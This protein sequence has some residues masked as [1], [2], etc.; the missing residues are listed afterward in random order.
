NLYSSTRGIHRLLALVR[1]MDLLAE[2]YEVVQRGF[3]VPTISGLRDYVASSAP[4]SNAG[5][6][7]Y[8]DAHPSAGD[9]AMTL[10]WSKD[11]NERIARMVHGIPPFPHVRQSLA[12]I[13]QQADIVIV[14]ATQG[15]ALE[16]EWSEHDILRYVSLV[17]GQEQGSK[18]QI[19]ASL[20]PMYQPEHVLMIG[21]APGDWDAARRNAALFYPIRPDEEEQS[22]QE[23]AQSGQ[24]FFDGEYA[25]GYEKKLIDAFDQLLPEKPAWKTA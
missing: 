5:M 9:V 22:W 8:L 13:A 19:I 16:R 7:A 3:T 2:R 21:D 11:V 17:C 1:V 20:A 10:D 23:F 15:L 18:A 4:L 6:Q 25:G 12:M 14:S 24:R